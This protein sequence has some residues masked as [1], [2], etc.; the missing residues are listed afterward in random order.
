MRI[1]GSKLRKGGRSRLGDAIIF[2]FIVQMSVLMVAPLVYS[3]M[4]SFKPLD[5]LFAYPPRFMVNRPTFNNYSVLF[6][7]VADLRVPFSRY[8]FNS[9]TIS[10]LTTAGSVLISSLA[11]YPLSKYNLRAKRLFDL[12]VLTLLFNGTVLVLPQYVILSKLHII[13]T[14]LVYIVPNLAAPLGLFLMKQFMERVPMA[15][16]ESALIDGANQYQIFFR[17]VMPQVKPAWLT[18]VLF[19][20]QA[21]WAQQPLNMVFDEDIKLLNMAFT[22]VNSAGISRIG[23]AMASAVVLMIPLILVFVATQSNVIETMT[24]SGIKE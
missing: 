4:N 13:N 11:A 5:E 21:V 19:T 2:I 1:R 3:V 9:I 17:I 15:L 6:R 7:L 10:F 23:P 16:I 22:S 18:L 8:L 20:F 12:V 24:A 14:V